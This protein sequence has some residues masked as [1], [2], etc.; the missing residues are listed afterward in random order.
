MTCLAFTDAL[1]SPIWNFSVF[2]DTRYHE[3]FLI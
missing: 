1:R 2:I 3:A